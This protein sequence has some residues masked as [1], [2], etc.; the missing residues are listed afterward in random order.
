MLRYG[1]PAQYFTVFVRPDP[2][3]AKKLITT[4]NE[5]FEPFTPQPSSASRDRKGKSGGGDDA[6]GEYQN[7]L[8]QELFNYVLFEVPS[9]EALGER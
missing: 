3:Q 2:K 9:L 5:H 1:L 8:E 4:L 6:V 7:V